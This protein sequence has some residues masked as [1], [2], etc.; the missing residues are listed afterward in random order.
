MH[1]SKLEWKVGLFVCVGLVLLA[2][3]L[4][5]F[6]KGASFFRPHYDIR[7]RATSSSGLRENAQVLMAGVQVGFVHSIRL[8]ADGKS[9]VMTLRIYRPFE[10]RKDSRFVIEQSGFLG[11][12]YVSI[13]PTGNEGPVLRPGEEARAEA[14]VGIQD[15]ART[16][17]GLIRQMNTAA[18]NINSALIDA[19]QTVFSA[20]TLTNVSETLEIFRR[21]SERGLAVADNVNSLVETN[22]AAIATSISNLLQFSEALNHSANTFRDLL[23]TNAPGIRT[24]VQNVESSSASVKELL[25][26]VKQGRGLAGKLL[27]NEEIAANV[28]QIASNLSITTSNLNR[29]GLWGVLWGHKEW[30][31]P[32]SS[33]ENPLRA[34]KDPFE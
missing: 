15:V 12:Q 30:R 27:E 17:A 14:P 33:A 32:P 18:T 6:T 19:R 11:D 20:E 16:A 22:R 7:L 8:G 26:G 1:K 5:Q 31:P 10:I 25:D 2:I 23:A 28:S 3:L 21:A 4:L 34:P 29:R 13:Q 9:V 24:T